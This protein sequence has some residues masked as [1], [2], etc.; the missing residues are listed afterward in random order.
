MLELD[1]DWRRGDYALRAQARLDARATGLCGDSGAGKSTLLA[2]IA[3][4]RRPDRGRI[5]LDGETLVDTARRVWL[6][7]ER[8]H[9]GLVFQD[10]QL[11]PHLDVRANLRYGH[12][13]RAPAERH[14]TLD[15]IVSLLEI[16]HLLARR[17]RL[18]SGGEKQRVALGRALL[19]SPRLLLLDEP[20]AALDD[21][22]KQQI[23][24][25]L[26]R[27]RDDLGMPLLYVSHARAE[28]DYLAEQVWRVADGRLTP[29]T[30]TGR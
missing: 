1:L 30:G 4:L 15:D 23:L 26:L 7:P 18:L 5:A 25:F 13:L 29:E 27:I 12:D 22:R 24:P 11:F 6:P 19:Q 2:L 14:F 3:G 21:S 17:P 9:I 8:R 28:V 20:L 10:A 16:G